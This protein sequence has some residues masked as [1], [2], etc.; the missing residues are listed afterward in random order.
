MH[1][2]NTARAINM[3]RENLK[4]SFEIIDIAEH[5]ILFGSKNNVTAAKVAGILAKREMKI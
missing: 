5:L 1:L 3:R 4:L 2:D